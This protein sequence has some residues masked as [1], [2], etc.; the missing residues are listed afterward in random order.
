M[1]A[2]LGM[3]VF[4]LNTVPYQNLKRSTEWRWAS[5][6]RIGKRPSYQHIGQGVDAISLS[7]VL[8]PGFTGG[9]TSLDALRAMGDSGMAWTLIDGEGFIYG[10]YFIEKITEDRT[11]FFSDGAPRK[12]EFTIDLKRSDD[13]HI[14]KLGSLTRIGLAT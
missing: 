1:M 13:T 10:L 2:A 12:I 7:G 11:E 8:M 14:D 4:N 9:R 5:N 6:S 3:F